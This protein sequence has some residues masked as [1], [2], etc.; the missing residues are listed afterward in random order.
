LQGG[1]AAMGRG[2]NPHPIQ[3]EALLAKLGLR[4]T[5]AMEREHTYGARFSAEICT[6]GCHWIPRMHA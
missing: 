3:R 1:S 6:R 2:C 5:Y 4:G